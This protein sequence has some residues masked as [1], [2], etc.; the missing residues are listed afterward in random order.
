MRLLNTQTLEFE[1]FFEFNVPTYLILSHRWEG[2]ETSFQV[3][4]ASKHNTFHPAYASTGITKIRT[5]CNLAEKAGFQ[6]AWID[7]CCIDKTSS[8][9][10]TEAINS[11][12]S[13]YASATA[14]YVYLSDV[15]SEKDHSMKEQLCGSRWF[16]RGWTLQELLAPRKQHFFDSS[17]KLLGQRDDDTMSEA[18]STITGISTRYFGNIKAIR[19]ATIAERMHWVSTRETSRIEDLAYCMLG[20]FGINIP[21]IYGEGLNAFLRLQTEIIKISDDETIF[22]W[23]DSS[24]QQSGLLANHPKC[25]AQRPDLHISDIQPK[26]WIHRLPFSMTNKGIELE[27]WVSKYHKNQ[28]EML[29]P[30]NCAVKDR[31]WIVIKLGRIDEMTWR[32]INC[33]TLEFATNLGNPNEETLPEFLT[34][35]TEPNLPP[36]LTFTQNFGALSDFQRQTNIKQNLQ[37][38]KKRCTIYVRQYPKEELPE[39]NI[40]QGQSSCIVTT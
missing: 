35:D 30:I 34:I 5:F 31:G 17:W 39:T 14:C 33:G 11:M 24:R 20:I 6:W 27:V 13:W 19:S 7:T 26:L 28:P 10:L 38:A 12:W 3:F 8:A 32:R 2:K 40:R 36:R 18:L 25:F 23:T 37:F 16:T 22:A 21:L 15:V 4:E 1:E 9:E 29:L